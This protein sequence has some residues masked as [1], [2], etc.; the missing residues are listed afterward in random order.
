MSD[1][2]GLTTFDANVQMAV[3]EKKASKG[4][5]ARAAKRHR[6]VTFRDSEIKA[7]DDRTEELRGTS[8]KDLTSSHDLFF[9]VPDYK[10]QPGHQSRFAHHFALHWRSF[11]SLLVEILLVVLRF[12]WGVVVLIFKFLWLIVSSLL[13]IVMCVFLCIY[14]VL[15]SCLPGSDTIFELNTQGVQD[16]RVIRWKNIHQLFLFIRVQPNGL[17]ASPLVPLREMAPRRMRRGEL[18][19]NLPINNLRRLIQEVA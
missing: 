11:F 19:Q 1:K 4:A 3:G 5:V 7:E 17:G 14:F 8:G 18:V 15:T 2:P 10:G 9:D 16:L 6:T 13:Q 12:V